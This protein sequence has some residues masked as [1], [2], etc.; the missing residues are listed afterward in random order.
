MLLANCKLG[1]DDTRGSARG[2]DGSARR[3]AV[4]SQPGLNAQVLCCHLH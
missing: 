2:G 1:Q 4:G 3:D